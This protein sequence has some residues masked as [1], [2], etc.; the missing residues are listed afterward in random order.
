MATGLKLGGSTIKIG[1]ISVQPVETKESELK[2]SATKQPITLALAGGQLSSTTTAPKK[3]GLPPLDITYGVG[4][5][6]PLQPINPRR[7]VDRPKLKLASSTNNNY[8]PVQL[9][10]ISNQRPELIFMVDY[11]PI[12]EKNST[13]LTSE[14]KFLDVLMSARDLRNEELVN[15][16]KQLSESESTIGIVEK[17]RK[18]WNKQMDLAIEEVEFLRSVVSVIKSSK[19]SL[20]IRKFFGSDVARGIRTYKSYFTNELQFTE[21]GFKN[22]SNT[23]L[24]LQLIF[25]LKIAS[26]QYSPMLFDATDSDRNGDRDP[27]ELDKTVNLNDGKFSFNI[28]NFQSSNSDIIHMS[29]QAEHETL[30]RSL[31]TNFEDKIKL[32]T[33]TL[34]KEIRVSNGLGATESQTYL[35]Q[36]GA[37]NTGNPFENIMGEPGEKITDIPLGESSISSIGRFV[38]NDN[39]VVLPFEKYFLT[40][41]NGRTY[42]PGNTYLI[43][44]ILE[45]E[46]RFDLG[47]IREFKRS[48]ENKIEGTTSLFNTLL[49]I[50]KIENDPSFSESLLIHVLEDISNILDRA[51]EEE[52][53]TRDYIM[54]AIIS[55]VST[56]ARLKSM[57]FQYIVLLG[58]SD[59]VRGSAFERMSRFE[60][61]DLTDFTE[62]RQRPE[63]SK[64][65]KEIKVTEKTAVASEART[66]AF[67]MS[68]VILSE[69]KT[70]SG[71]SLDSN[72]EKEN[73]SVESIADTLTSVESNYALVRIIEFINFV[74][75]L[76]DRKGIVNDSTGRSKFN[77]FSVSTR[78]V[79]AFELYISLLSR[80]SHTFFSQ[81]IR[82]KTGTSGF[83]HEVQ[84]SSNR[85]NIL[86][87]SKGIGDVIKNF[88]KTTRNPQRGPKLRLGSS[89]VNLSGLNK[90][91]LKVDNSALSSK[92]ERLLS[93]TKKSMGE[94]I[95]KLKAEDDFLRDG[96][97]LLKRTFDRIDRSVERL[98]EFFG[99]NSPNRKKI[100][101][102]ENQV[103]SNDKFAVL[104]DAQV[105]LSRAL[106]SETLVDNV[107]SGG[108][109]K[110]PIEQKRKVSQGTKSMWRPFL[111]DSDISK[112]ARESLFEFLNDQKLSGEN[113]TD[114]KILTV[115]I[116]TGFMEN[117]RRRVEV[118][119]VEDINI[120]QQQIDVVSVNVYRKNLEYEDIVF[121]PKRY[122]F[123]MSRF[124]S[125]QRVSSANGDILLQPHLVQ[126]NFSNETLAFVNSGDL[127]NDKSYDF[128]SGPE[129]REMLD[130]HMFDYLLGLY[131]KIFTG[132]STSEEE[133]LINDE[134]RQN[135]IDEESKNLFVDLLLGHIG[136][137]AGKTLTLQ[138]LANS[139]SQIKNLL[140]KLENISVTQSS[141][142]E[143]NNVLIE[144]VPE[145]VSIEM[146]EN[147]I[148]LMKLFGPNSF[149]S[150]PSA[151]R[152]QIT[153]PKLF[154]RIFNIIVDP[155]D[156]EVDTVKTNWSFTE[157]TEKLNSKEF[158]SLT[159]ENGDS[160]IK[161]SPK[162]TQDSSVIMD[163]YFVT[164]STVGGHVI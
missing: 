61:D 13:E 116:P 38:G 137:L 123:E 44:P 29:N 25:D 156:F 112:K 126:K 77:L 10:G 162:S 96:I 147:L 45:N 50:N 139:S 102:L 83:S 76:I 127:I 134:I 1:N 59:E 74:D 90:L 159:D 140:D 128:L 3:T 22:F 110:T 154:E 67:E 111:D 155:S 161:M 14:G 106:L 85:T 48:F 109:Q 49:K 52:K 136:E 82:R 132:L 151:K 60:F 101:E 80:F 98:E 152:N 131:I 105:N 32:L 56:N 78:S 133:Y 84:V 63:S 119:E 57:L 18:N 79:M 115:G 104:D 81:K 66:L 150:G 42:V 17:I 53:I 72:I 124:M 31:P 125:R 89:P 146:T 11:K 65:P 142:Q 19:D 114:I 2:L 28:G 7:R 69:I 73:F 100:D 40:D 26:S 164:V 93:N 94:A 54:L 6:P 92:Q 149:L 130:N 12:Y 5:T 37:N 153:S 75:D 21:N 121:K 120:S 41:E 91:E 107:V 157:L 129:K 35:S 33:I 163:E 9:A 47:K 122:I 86:L 70:Y 99:R 16:I 68:R 148:N 103:D 24:F 118:S 145:S 71:L 20:D 27:I 8:K 36:F 108:R 55:M 58:L 46:P 95:R 39:V 62:V 143:I 144:D 15:L 30:I 141:L 117:L 113:S 158:I 160:I 87:R 97:S 43:D 23:K 138:D 51:T 88:G 34:S 135:P 4:F 64:N